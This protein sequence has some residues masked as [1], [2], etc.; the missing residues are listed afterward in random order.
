VCKDFA[1]SWVDELLGFARRGGHA[2][3][4]DEIGESFHGQSV[5]ATS[6]QG[7]AGFDT[8]RFGKS[9]IWPIFGEVA[10]EYRGETLPKLRIQLLHPS[11][12][13]RVALMRQKNRS[14]HLDD[15]SKAIIE[16]LQG[17]GRKPYAA[18]GSAVG[19]SEAAV[20]QRV[21]KLVD[22]GVIQIVAVTDP[23]TVGSFRMA[24]IGVRVEGDITSV[25]DQLG[26]Y[27]EV[28]YVVVTAGNF[29]ILVEVIC[30]DDEHLLELLQRIR[31]IPSVRSTESFVYLKLQK[32]LYNWGT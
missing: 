30:D 9:A 31:A 17:D 27:R 24:M 14:V 5:R 8:A 25:A 2:L 15:A 28:D 16:Q 10:Y 22:S 20:R 29:D 21:Q 11:G 32:Q 12:H 3:A 4:I 1:G 7:L 23:L 13:E 18:I 19:L 6:R 26:K